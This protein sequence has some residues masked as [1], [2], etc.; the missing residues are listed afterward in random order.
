M[1]LCTLLQSPPQRPIIGCSMFAQFHGYY[2]ID[3]YTL[4]KL[5]DICR[6]EKEVDWY[7]SPFTLPA[8][9]SVL[10]SDRWKVIF[11][12]LQD[13]NIWYLYLCILFNSSN[14]LCF[15][16]LS[17]CLWTDLV[18]KPYNLSG[19]LKCLLKQHA[20]TLSLI[21]PPLFKS[22]TIVGFFPLTSACMPSGEGKLVMAHEIHPAVTSILS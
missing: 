17:S 19:H 3:I 1:I 4:F 10:I 14:E 22:T 7:W 21:Q 2:E 16:Y 20:C 12:S 13:Q 15:K 8:Q 9:T 11:N 5:Y 6:V 18:H